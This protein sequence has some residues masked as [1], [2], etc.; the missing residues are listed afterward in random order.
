M[1]KE[2]WKEHFENPVCNPSFFRGWFRRIANSRPAGGP[3]EFKDSPGNPIRSC[4]RSKERCRPW[5]GMHVPSP[6]FSL[7]YRQSRW[8]SHVVKK[9]GSLCF[10]TPAHFSGVLLTS[11][12]L[13]VLVVLVPLQRE[14]TLQTWLGKPF[15]FYSPGHWLSF[16]LCS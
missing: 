9:H 6:G 14:P 16:Q 5:T 2:M 3:G 10:R 4:F 15:Q 8:V 11:L 7:W 13:L 12:V 1:K